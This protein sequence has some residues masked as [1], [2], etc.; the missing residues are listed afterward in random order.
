AWG[1]PWKS[2][3]QA[4]GRL[5]FGSDW[6]VASLNIGRAMKIATSRI[7]H[8]PVP[9]QKLTVAEVIDGYTRDAAWS[10]DVDQ[11][12]GTLTPGKLADIVIF[13]DDIFT[14]PLTG[15]D[16]AIAATLMDGKIVYRGDAA[17]K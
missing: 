15:G 17:V 10:I 16:L 3:K 2:I 7:P 1:W 13:R 5:A 6:P 14:E 9:D 12:R 4:G 11:D 8:P